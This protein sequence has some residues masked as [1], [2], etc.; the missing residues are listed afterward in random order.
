MKKLVIFDFDGTLADTSPGILYCYNAAAVDFGYEKAPVERFAGIIGGHVDEG[1]QKVF[2]M[3][4][5]QSFAAAEKYREYYNQKGQRMATLYPGM[6][7]VLKR[8]KEQEKKIALATLKHERFAEQM[9]IFL[10]IRDYFDGICAFNGKSDCTKASLLQNA[11]KTLQIPEKDSVLVG[12]SVFDAKGAE[13]VGMDFIAVLYGL[14]FQ[15]KEDLKDLQI[16]AV[17][18]TPDQLLDAVAAL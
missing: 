8:L 16:S 1:M 17:C 9:L 13:T 6:E 18:K 3:E 5:Q 4:K 15:K 7:T 11:C 10:K 2:G 12:D 14:G